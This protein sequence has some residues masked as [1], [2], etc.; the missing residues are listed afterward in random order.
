MST[1]QAGQERCERCGGRGWIVS[2]ESPFTATRCECRAAGAGPRLL[3]AAGIPE[4]YRRCSLENFTIEV[5]DRGEK[6]Q[7]FEARSRA[8]DYVDSF[9]GE[10]GRFAESGL[11]F[12]GPAGVG[13]THLAAAVLRE[14]IERYRVHGLFVDFTSLIHQIQ[15]TF[16]PSSERSK[17]EVLDPVI[18]AEVLVLDELGA[19]KPSAWVSE[20]LYLILNSRYTKRLPTLFTTNFFLEP[21]DTKRPEEL[22]R[23]PDK[24]SEWVSNSLSTRIP[25]SLVSR[26]YE[27]AREVPINAGDFRREVKAAR[28]LG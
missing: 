26:L 1:A 27:M 21:R 4:R 5:P 13:K 11:L 17:H 28:L 9:V 19:Q 6:D 8:K 2:G 18:E 14:L 3:T 24:S 15:A 12:S 25:A 10:G 22:D 7:L 23:T 20:I 16:D